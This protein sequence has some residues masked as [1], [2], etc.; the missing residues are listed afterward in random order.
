VRRALMNACGINAILVVHFVEQDLSTPVSEFFRLISAWSK[1]DELLLGANQL[2]GRGRDSTPRA[3]ADIAKRLKINLL[4]LPA[5][6]SSQ[7]SGRVRGH[8]RKGN[9]RKAIRLVGRP[10]VWNMPA[11]GLLRLKWPAGVYDCAP[12]N[13]PLEKP[14]RKR[15]RLEMTLQKNGSSKMTWPDKSIQWLAFISGPADTK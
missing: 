5:D 11:R 8:I 2:F 14:G 9:L 4:R 13:H 10:P 15:L 12:L 3:L 6:S 1:I 7:I